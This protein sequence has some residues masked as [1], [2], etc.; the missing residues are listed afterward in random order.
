METLADHKQKHGVNC[1]VF[2]TQN[3][4]R[5]IFL[6]RKNLTKTARL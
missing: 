2:K 1:S 5:I 4:Q 6:P 3:K